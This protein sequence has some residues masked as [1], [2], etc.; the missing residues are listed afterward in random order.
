ML[1]FENLSDVTARVNLLEAY[2]TS[3]GIYD[4]GSGAADPMAIMMM[5]PHEDT[6]TDGVVVTLM[7]RIM[8]SK[9]PEYTG[10]SLAELMMWPRYLLE[11]LLKKAEA[12]KK[13]NAA[14]LASTLNGLK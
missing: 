10:S 1:E 11:Q 14:D 9:L 13:I 5:H 12:E 8:A 7:F 3:Y 6:T 4:H 2:D